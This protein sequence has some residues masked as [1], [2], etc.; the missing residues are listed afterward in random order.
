[1]PK[2]FVS[3]TGKRV[4]WQQLVALAADTVCG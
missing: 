1:V 2:V 3:V 4:D